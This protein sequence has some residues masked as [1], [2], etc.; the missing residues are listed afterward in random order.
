MKIKVTAAAEKKLKEKMAGKPGFL[1]LKYDIDGC[2]CAVNGVAA[3]WLEDERER[4][5]T[6][7]RTDSFP[8]YIEAS[9]EVFF[10]DEM[11]IDYSAA[12]GCY[13]LKSPNEY[14]NPR[15]SYLD[16]TKGK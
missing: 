1:K 2:G 7:I 9:R 3:L 14:L 15:M 11:T 13:Q 12:T 4:N 5:E 8:I 16:K 6:E 10:D